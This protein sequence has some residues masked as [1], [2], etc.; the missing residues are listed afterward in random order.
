MFTLRRI[1]CISILVVVVLS[2]CEPHAAASDRPVVSTP[3]TTRAATA[4]AIPAQPPSATPTIPSSTATATR[5][6]ESLGAT[7][8]NKTVGFELNYATSWHIYDV[9]A[10]IEK[11]SKAYSVVLTSWQPQPGGGQGIPAGGTKVDISVIESS[12]KTLQEAIAER[13]EQMKAATPSERILSEQEWILAGGLRAMRWQTESASG[14][15]AVVV[16]FINGRTVMLNGL[17]NVWAFDQIAR[18]LRFASA[19]P[20][21][22]SGRILFASK[23]DGKMQLYVMNADGSKPT[24]LT[25]LPD[26]I[27]FPAPSPDG[28]HIAFLSETRDAN[29]WPKDL[30][31]HVMQFNGSNP[32]NLLPDPAPDV[33]PAWSPDGMLIAFASARE[34][35]RFR[36][37][38]YVIK[39]D[40][41]GL[42]KLID[43]GDVPTWSPDGKQIA[44]LSDRD[45]QGTFQIYVMDADGSNARQLTNSPKKGN[46]AGVGAP[47]WSPDGT[48][49]AFPSDRD[50]NREIYLMNAD[51]SNQVNLT[52]NKAYDDL[53]V[54]SPDGKRI[55]FVSDRSGKPG[56]HVMN[57]DGSNVTDLSKG[58]RAFSPRW[59][60][61]GTRLVFVSDDGNDNQDIYVISADGTGLVNLTQHPAQDTFPVWL[62]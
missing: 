15:V 28:T 14:Q 16:T 48:R 5:S 17:G 40:G 50:G 37:S 38:L 59:S 34:G 32:V 2:A 29:G 18:T 4:T 39:P 8:R 44:F 30:S 9:S 11:N 51:G 62:P 31:L 35:D 26:W 42:K 19:A 24:Q 45:S 46:A 60:L 36:R 49:I 25:N 47:A 12:A 23:R 41:T 7:Y 33:A 13:K 57:V 56:V 21:S 10:E 3:T 58:L 55:A 61:D 43:N 1:Q 6:G 22:T 53:P 52:S 27:G 54:W 20:T